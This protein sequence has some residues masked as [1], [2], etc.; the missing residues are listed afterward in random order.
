MPAPAS[1]E[2]VIQIKP[3]T[4]CDWTDPAH[5][6]G[7]SCGGQ[8]V[9]AAEEVTICYKAGYYAAEKLLTSASAG[10]VLFREGAPCAGEPNLRLEDLAKLSRT[11][12][13]N[14]SK[15]NPDMSTTYTT[16][17]T[18]V[19]NIADFSGLPNAVLSGAER[20]SAGSVSIKVKCLGSYSARMI[21]VDA[22]QPQTLATYGTCKFSAENASCPGTPPCNDN[23][24]CKPGYST[25]TCSCASGYLPPACDPRPSQ[26]ATRLPLGVTTVLPIPPDASVSTE[27]NHVIVQ[28]HHT[29]TTY[30]FSPNGTVEI[31]HPNNSEPVII[32][33]SDPHMCSGGTEWQA[34]SSGCLPTCRN[35][36]PRCL[37]TCLHGACQ[38]PPAI[39]L[40]DDITQ[41]CVAAEACSEQV[42]CPGIGA[43]C[44]GHGDCINS[45]CQCAEMF[46]GADCSV[47]SEKE[48]RVTTVSGTVQAVVPCHFPFTFR[49]KEYTDCTTDY[50]SDGKEWCSVTYE[51]EHQW[52]FCGPRGSC[53]EVN[54][55]ACNG[56]GT[57]LHGKCTCQPN[58]SGEDCS[59]EY[60]RYANTTHQPCAFPFLGSDMVNHYDCIPGIP[61]VENGDVVGTT[62]A[63]GVWWCLTSF[64]YDGPQS[65]GFCA[66][67]GTCGQ[68]DTEGGMCDG[69]GSGRCH[70]N[71]GYQGVTC[72]KKMTEREILIDLF[73]ST[74]GP[75]WI[76]N[77]GW[78]S[79]GSPCDAPG[80]TGVSCRDGH[81]VRLNLD[82]TGLTGTIPPSLSALNHLEV[83][84]LSNNALVGSFPRSLLYRPTTLRYISVSSNYLV[85]ETPVLPARVVYADFR[86]NYMK[87]PSD[88][89]EATLQTRVT[90]GV[91]PAEV[92]SECSFPFEF[93]GKLYNHCT[94]DWSDS[95]QAWCSVTREFDGKWGRCAP[96]GTCPGANGQQCSG[97]G[98]CV[99]SGT[100]SSLIGTCECDEG[101]KGSMCNQEVTRVTRAT[102]TG[103]IEEQH[104]RPCQFP[105]EYGGKVYRDCT[106]DD[107]PTGE[108]WCLT[109]S[110]W[111]RKWGFCDEQDA[112]PGGSAV[113]SGHGDCNDGV[114]ECDEG[115]IWNDCS[116]KMPR[117]TTGSRFG[118]K[119]QGCQFPFSVRGVEYKDCVA[120]PFISNTSFCAV[121]PGRLEDHHKWDTCAPAGTC[122][123]NT[124]CSDNGE[125][126]DGECNCNAGFTGL[127]CS[128]AMSERDILTKF[129]RST[130]GPKWL[131]NTNWEITPHCDW[132]GVSCNEQNQTTTISLSQNNLDGTIPAD[133]AYLA[134][135]SSLD[136]SSNLLAGTVPLALWTSPALK[137][138]NIV[139][140]QLV[141]PLPESAASV[142]CDGNC[143]E[144]AQCA[145]GS[146]QYL[147]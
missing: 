61:V 125:C 90:D 109:T 57:C 8:C 81:V 28:D 30:N 25:S 68:C 99:K 66:P 145:K 18:T 146:C 102:T 19:H 71:P 49:G 51:W 45:T 133:L 34:C 95:E 75:E 111:E 33:S 42:A 96:A 79:D 53:P 22:G 77:T 73:S 107:S 5:T 46:S 142:Q 103:T 26:N 141:G 84:D 69:F 32:T 14:S 113:C 98:K 3:K 144:S 39:P 43:V 131:D 93:R 54:G 65:I 11:T 92:Y 72:S 117:A 120:L 97:H 23:G 124:P 101:Y 105:F 36:N 59:F 17:T 47:Y 56:R 138:I 50:D 44:S 4:R 140:N 38:C 121:Q 88:D 89:G 94:T 83:L 100:G 24:F 9:A 27:G 115:Y 74:K 82:S 58:F 31:N 6:T 110:H 143:I 116:Q 52:A 122:P 139:N 7:G 134:K 130:N 41:T 48:Q 64:R 87:E 126:Y 118:G 106:T 104:R 135:L 128:L 1:H 78:G 15:V 80:W 127:D 114:C 62:P 76:R 70:C 63:E 20:R 35:P 123:G 132:E 86:Q 29:N 2:V 10:I 91:G 13:T 40:W 37:P 137:S 119:S 12:H 67:S 60:V 129:F 16:T 55:I 147:F 112:C 108:E 85:G 136:L 21:V